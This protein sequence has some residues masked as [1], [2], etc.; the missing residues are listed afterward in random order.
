MIRP[1]EEELKLDHE[2]G[3]AC[4]WIPH[5]LLPGRPSH[6]DRI[7]VG[8]SYTVIA[9]V[10]DDGEVGTISRSVKVSAILLDSSPGNVDVR[11]VPPQSRCWA[12]VD[13]YARCEGVDFDTRCDKYE[14]TERK[15]YVPVTMLLSPV[16]MVQVCPHAGCPNT[17]HAQGA[18]CHEGNPLFLHNEYFIKRSG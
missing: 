2:S 3:V 15:H 14:L 7:E 13:Y 12:V 17:I 5:I 9:E 16:H 18:P 11:A 6:L 1:D 10:D 8:G 4:Q